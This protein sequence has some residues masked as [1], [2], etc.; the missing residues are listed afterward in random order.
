MRG[1]ERGFTLVEMLVAL[2]IFGM[3]ASSAVV[4]LG[5]AVR[6]QETADA[7]LE[8]AAALRRA[9]AML[10]ADLAQAAPRIHRDS[11]GMPHP[12]FVGGE[13]QE[14]L[15]ALVR[16]GWDN[17]GGAARSS[18]QK[19]EYRLA[20]DRIERIAYPMVDGAAPL[21][22]VPLVAGVRTAGLRFRD[23]D[24]QWRERWDPSN[25]A[26]LPRAVELV[27]EA[28]GVGRLRQLFLARSGAGE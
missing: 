6:A 24:G 3:L 5:V 17:H 12:A 7:K 8:G 13:G 25:P 9:G 15:I 26:A 4:L 19:V 23:A 28:E 1:A 14:V 18:L 22:P 16:R 27:I 21:A 2:A 11:G 10:A 20:E